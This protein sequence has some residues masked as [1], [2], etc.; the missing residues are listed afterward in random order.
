MV[1]L[2]MAKARWRRL[3]GATYYRSC[4][5]ASSSWTASSRG[6]TSPRREHAVVLMYLV[7]VEALKTRLTA[8]DDLV[9]RG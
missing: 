1:C 6:G 9:T 4:V 3:D 2:Y 7:M 8:H 5:P